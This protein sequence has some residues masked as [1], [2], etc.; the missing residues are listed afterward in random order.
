MIGE[1]FHMLKN[2]LH[3]PLRRLRIIQ[4]NVVSN[5]IQIVKRRLGPDYFSHRAM[6][7][8]AWVW[9]RVRPSSTAFSP[10]AMPSSRLMRRCCV[11]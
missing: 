1:L 9:D 2:P 10:R 7:C 5:G 6:R 8:V 3:H 11:S 4:R